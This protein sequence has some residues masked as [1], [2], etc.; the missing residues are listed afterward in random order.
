MPSRTALAL[1]LLS[2]AGLAACSDSDPKET[3]PDASVPDAPPDAP[4][5]DPTSVLPA[6]LRPIA[7][8]SAGAVTVTTD[9]NVT[10][11]T[12]D[13][14]AGG[15]MMSADN[16]FIYVDLK[17]N[18]R[19]DVNDLDARSSTTWDIALK[20]ANI[21]VNGGDSG[22]GNRK[23]VVAPVATLAELTAAPTT[24]YAADDFTTADCKLDATDGGE[25]KS[26]FANW[27]N[28]DDATHMLSPKP[29]VY[30]IERNN[31]THVAFQ[32]DAYY[33]GPNKASAYYVVKWKNL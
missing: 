17:N 25:L 32:I 11:G 31:G 1:T 21:V 28:Y 30:V 22:P 23:A 16:P 13:A 14:T 7:K 3:T 10:S 6:S 33:G 19:V 20:R 8:I 5:C 2:A 15:S 27:Y 26:G 24:G 9:Q 29:Q 18:V 4:G 12:I